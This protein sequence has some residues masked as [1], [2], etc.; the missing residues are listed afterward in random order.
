MAKAA[1]VPAAP[2]EKK[3]RQVPLDFTITQ[4]E[5]RASYI[6][7]GLD[8]AHYTGLFE[9]AES[10]LKI[11]A[12]ALDWSTHKEFGISDE[13]FAIANTSGDPVT[14]A[15]YLCHP[16][17]LISRPEM[18]KY[19]RCISTF[20]QKG[21]K[22]V[23]GVSSADRL[24][25]GRPI[26]QAKAAALASA[27]N[28]NLG[29]IYRVALPSLDKLKAIM[30][31]TAGISIDGGWKNAVGSE[32]E[33]VIK[34]VIVRHGFLNSEIVSVTIPNSRMSNGRKSGS[35][36]IP[37]KEITIDWI[38]NHAGSFQSVLFKNGSIAVFGSEPDVTLYDSSGQ[39]VAGI[40]VKAGLDPAGALERLGAMLKSFDAITAIAPQAQRILVIA[41][42]TTEVDARLKEVA[43][44]SRQYSL[45]DIIKNTKGTEVRF[46]NMVRGLLGLAVGTH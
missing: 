46:A 23:S 19:Y 9:D 24:E 18:L 45:T 10:Y 39:T 38:D 5:L 25:T 27:I 37:A 41:C 34:S 1:N 21:I 16:S 40:E 6:S 33:R 32:G 42:L 3:A 8:S 11:N 44:L 43:A 14:L 31:A 36:A 28:G 20:S 13:V 26:D 7:T 22:A 17:L 15:H 29:P 35:T 4:Y 12:G 2:K 30:H